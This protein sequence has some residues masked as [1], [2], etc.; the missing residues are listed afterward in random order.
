[1][2]KKHEKQRFIFLFLLELPLEVTGHCQE[3]SGD[4]ENAGQE[5]IQGCFPTPE[6]CLKTCQENTTATG[7]EYD[8][9]NKDCYVHTA[10]LTGVN[11]NKTGHICW[12]FVGM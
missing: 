11:T 3:R 4:D 7:C 8:T 10:H 12:M 5:V 6:D 9:L 1:M 2:H